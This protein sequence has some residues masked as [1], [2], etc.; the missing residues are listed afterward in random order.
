MLKLKEKY[1]DFIR[2][3]NG[4]DSLS[5]NILWFIVLGAFINLKYKNKIISAFLI[6]ATLFVE[7]RMYF[8]RSNKPN[9]E[10]KNHK[11]TQTKQIRREGF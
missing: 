1:E 9:K 10:N 4:V 8:K 5:R 7:F 6:S 2:G 3:I 11:P